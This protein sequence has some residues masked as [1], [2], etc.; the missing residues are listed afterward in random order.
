MS[1]R[2]LAHTRVSEEASALRPLR[3]NRTGRGRHRSWRAFDRGSRCAPRARG[4]VFRALGGKVTLWHLLNARPLRTRRGADLSACLV[5][6]ARTNRRRGAFFR[7]V[8]ARPPDRSDCLERGPATAGRFCHLARGFRRA[9]HPGVALEVRPRA[10]DPLF[11]DRAALPH[12]A[13]RRLPSADPQ[14]HT[15]EPRSPLPAAGLL[16]LRRA[17]PA[18]ELSGGCTLRPASSPKRARETP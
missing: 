7:R 12:T 15:Y 9:L 18:I 4:V 17:T 6:D 13:R 11:T 8:P 3:S 1:F 14:A 10:L 5:K 2:L 16:G